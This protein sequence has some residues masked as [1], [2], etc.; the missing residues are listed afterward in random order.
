MRVVLLC[1]VACRAAPAPVSCTESAP[2]SGPSAIYLAFDG[3]TLEP[4]ERSDATQNRFSGISSTTII[5]PFR[6]TELISDVVAQ[7]RE[8]LAPFAVEVTTERPADDYIMIVFAGEH[9]GTLHGLSYK[10]CGNLVR[11]DVAVF[12]EGVFDESKQP[13]GATNEV[14]RGLMHALGLAKTNGPGHPCSCDPNTCGY[15]SLCV[16]SDAANVSFDTCP[17]SPEIQDD[18]LAFANVFGCR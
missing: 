6:R 9:R 2:P 5:P 13:Y 16:M 4:G 3:V 1:L 17:G 14:M 7:L 12:F 18:V 8:V 10:D 15:D 11:H